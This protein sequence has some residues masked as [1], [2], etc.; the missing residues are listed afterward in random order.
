MK[1]EIMFD[2]SKD[3]P[4]PSLVSRVAPVSKASGGVPAK[5]GQRSVLIFL[6]GDSNLTLIYMKEWPTET[7]TWRPTKEGFSSSKD[8]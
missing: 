7:W 8:S 3:V 2:P 1:V 4:Q 5:G 6:E